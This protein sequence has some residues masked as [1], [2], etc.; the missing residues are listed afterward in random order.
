MV[1]FISKEH[2]FDFT[3]I[4]KR[5][6]EIYPIEVKQADIYNLKIKKEQIYVY[7]YVIY[8]AVHLKLAQLSKPTRF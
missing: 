4:T 3:D 7:V 8:F 6:M 1:Y 5:I 2:Y